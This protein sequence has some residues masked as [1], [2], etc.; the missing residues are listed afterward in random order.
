MNPLKLFKRKHIK[1]IGETLQPVKL[2]TI[3]HVDTWKLE[4]KEYHSPTQGIK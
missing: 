4:A 2:T 1:R 3:N